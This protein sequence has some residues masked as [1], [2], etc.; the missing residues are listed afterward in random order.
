MGLYKRENSQF[1]WMS[2][3]ID[4]KRVFL[5]T[6]TKNKKMAEKIYAKKMTEIIEGKWSLPTELKR[7]IGEM[8]ARYEIECMPMKKHP[9]RDKSILKHFKAFFGEDRL[10][11]DI[12]H[13]LGDYEG[14]RAAKNAMPATISKE[15]GLLKRMFN[16]A[17]KKWKWLKENPVSY[18]EMPVVRNE[19]TRYLSD[20]E[21]AELMKAVDDPS[22]PEWLKPVILM[23][24]NTGLRESNLLGLKWSQVNLF[25]KMVVIDKAEMKN[26][27]ALSIPLTQEAMDIFIRRSKVR[28]DDLVFHDNGKEIYPVKLQRAMREICK[29]AKIDDF[30]FHDLRH[31]FASYL[32]QQGV[33]LHF[34]S[35][36]L[37]HRDSRMT[38]RYAHLSV[39]HLRDAIS[40]LDRKK[41]DGYI[42]V[43]PTL[44]NR[45]AANETY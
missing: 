14:F 38:L 15:L 22:S 44:H 20:N 36:L 30:R 43:T 11:K 23:A 13:N 8:I 16:I 45:V 39:E 27:D 6:E 5:S 24:L 2:Y 31:T 29:K 17:I 33:D 21:Y 28:T 25:S 37:G 40:T 9:A 35:K 32:R 18:I 3:R 1:Y 41:S 34:I 4:G 10:L 7:T 26:N 42:L 12:E 19:R